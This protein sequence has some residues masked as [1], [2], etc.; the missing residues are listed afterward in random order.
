MIVINEKEY[1]K[2]RVVGWIARTEPPTNAH[3][4]YILKLARLYKKVIIISGSCY[5]LGN[6]RHCIPSII[7]IKMI[8]AMLKDAG[9]S[10]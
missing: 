8:R 6:S 7:R 4:E 3:L 10:E 2:E 5:T 1:L 9:L